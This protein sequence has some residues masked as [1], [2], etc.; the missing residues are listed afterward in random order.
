M[1]AAEDKDIFAR[2]DTEDRILISADTDFS[3]LLELRTESKPS[4]ILFRKGSERRP[5]R[6]L[7]LLL[8]NLPG[9]QQ[10]LQLGSVVVL[11]PNRI[12]V[13]LLPIAGQE[14]A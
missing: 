1:Q 8:A 12:R 6:Q 9:I 14:E 4:V 11:E 5:Q 13:R 7:A 2:A 10:E 3:A